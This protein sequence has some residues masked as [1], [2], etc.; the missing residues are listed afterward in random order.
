LRNDDRQVN[1]RGLV[2][3]ISSRRTADLGPTA[4]VKYTDIISNGGHHRIPLEQ[5]ANGRCGSLL[6]CYLHHA[7]KHHG[8]IRT[9]DPHDL[10]N[11]LFSQITSEVDVLRSLIINRGEDGVALLMTHELLGLQ[12][13]KNRAHIVAVPGRKE[14]GVPRRDLLLMIGLRPAASRTILDL[15]CGQIYNSLS[16]YTEAKPTNRYMLLRA[17][18]L[19]ERN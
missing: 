5:L 12:V 4:R 13:A 18:T 10:V 17:R 19:R 1:K 3:T 8:V 9:C 14:H 16:L 11:I 2:R 15:S 6:P 7:L